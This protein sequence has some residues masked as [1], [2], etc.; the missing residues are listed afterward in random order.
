MS[1]SVVAL[2]PAYKEEETIGATIEALLNQD[3]VPDA[4]VVIPN[5]C[6]D[7]T[8]EIVRDYVSR[9]SRI[10]S[11][12][13]PKLEHKK[14]QALNL[15]WNK[16]DYVREA[17]IVICL[18]GDTVLPANA[19]GDWEREFQVT[20]KLGGSSSKFT[21]LGGDFLTRLQ[22]SEFAKWTD[23]ALRR[24]YTT[25]L[26]GTGCAISGQAL[27]E[28]VATT[29]RF[30][31]W[32]YDSQVEDFELTYQ[33]RKLGYSCRVSPTVRAYTDSMKELNS[34]WNQRMKWQ[35]GT[36]EDLLSI[37]VNRL[38]LVDWYQQAVGLLMAFVRIL[39]VVLI[40]LQISIGIFHFSMLWWLIIPIV[41]AVGE[42][43]MTFRIPHR[44][45]W[46]VVYGFAIFPQE[47]FATL[48]SGWF[49][50]AWASVLLS[51]I[52]GR[53]KDRWSLQYA[54]EAKV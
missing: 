23:T 47:I 36:V 3:R 41:F 21:M 37:G 14:P 15:A 49:L 38:T 30:G 13:L 5:G 17:D 26:A 2:I 52:T 48:R 39:W 10:V 1:L 33:I 6:P 22:R 50:A 29:N 20:A 27:R 40:V 43:L 54:A 24:G 9:D 42:G 28:V 35:V 7:R 51:K 19:I 45:R 34:L 44:D 46:D 31:P 32:S 11:Y 18:D 4:I 8:P 12:E 16:F 53:R 25:V